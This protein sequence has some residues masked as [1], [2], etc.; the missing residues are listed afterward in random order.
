ML[1][2]SP[3]TVGCQNQYQFSMNFTQP[4]ICFPSKSITLGNPYCAQAR[5][6][7]KVQFVCLVWV[8]CTVPKHDT[9]GQSWH[10]WKSTGAEC[11]HRCDCLWSVWL[12]FGKTT[13]YKVWIKSNYS[14]VFCIT[15][16]RHNRTMSGEDGEKKWWY[17]I[18]CMGQTPYIKQLKRAQARLD[19]S[20][21][22]AGQWRKGRADNGASARYE[23]TGPSVSLFPIKIQVFPLQSFQQCASHHFCVFFPSDF[24]HCM[25][26]LAHCLHQDLYRSS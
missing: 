21:V 5:L 10:D 8:L 2:W 1:V 11:R 19:R 9:L 25:S 26:V 23:T 4:Q 17:N 7:P 12:D 14:T 18:W 15:G 22:S 20:N 24:L 6:T 13:A 3:G 16:S